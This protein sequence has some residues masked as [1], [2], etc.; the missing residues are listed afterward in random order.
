MLLNTPFLHQTRFAFMVYGVAC[1]LLLS[2]SLRLSGA[3]AETTAPR[4]PKGHALVPFYPAPN[5]GELNLWWHEVK[6]TASTPIMISPTL[7][8]YVYSE[9]YYFPDQRQTQST[10]FWVPLPRLP[11][12]VGSSLEDMDRGPTPLPNTGSVPVSDPAPPLNPQTADARLYSSWFDPKQTL[13]RRQAIMTVGDGRLERHFGFETLTPIDFSYNG[14]RLLLKRRAGVLYV[15]LRC[16]D[17]VIW[18]KTRGVLEV[19]PELVQALEHQWRQ[20]LQSGGQGIEA[21]PPHLLQ[22]A[23][24]I[25]P[26]GFKAGQDDTFFYRAWAYTW[27]AGEQPKRF[28]LGLWEYNLRTQLPQLLA[29]NGWQLPDNLT[30]NALTYKVKPSVPHYRYGTPK[31]KKTASGYVWGHHP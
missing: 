5:Q 7:E 28:S 13:Q 8:G 18:D 25:E 30:Y 6:R 19:Y 10:L 9:A 21:V 24:D 2:A 16:S 14:Q 23:W 26:L 20:L 27:Q 4:L 11:L 12:G 31:K 3:L 29:F 22:M 17:V 15:G 1:L